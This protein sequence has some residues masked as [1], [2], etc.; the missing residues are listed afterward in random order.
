MDHLNSVA[1]AEK[2]ITSAD[3]YDLGCQTVHIYS[4]AHKHI[5]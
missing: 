2:L 5:E 4:G 1:C 3:R